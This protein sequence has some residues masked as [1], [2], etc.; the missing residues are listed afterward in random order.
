MASTTKIVTA[1]IALTELD[2][3]KIIEVDKRAVGIEG[4]S[5]YLEEGEMLSAKSL[6]YAT[7]L[8]SAND[9]AAALAYEISGDIPSFA[10]KMNELAASLGLQNT[11]FTNPHGLDDKEHY[12]SAH[13]LALLT[14]YA[15]KNPLFLEIASTKRA[16]II[17]S[18]KN[19]TL[20]NH[21]K[22]LSSYEGCVGVKTGYT[23]KSG[24]SLVSAAERNGKMLISVTINAPDD[25]ID[26]KRMLDFGF[27]RCYI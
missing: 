8:S 11:N 25:W 9:A 19:R 22:L 7:L 15:I 24:R 26:H 1:V 3:D 6:V 16:E 23:K 21:N 12:T 10:M 14:A 13:D 4:S 5:V 20:V 17:S 18:L 27:S 2:S